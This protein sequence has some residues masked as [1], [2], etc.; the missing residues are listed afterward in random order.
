MFKSITSPV[1]VTHLQQNPPLTQ[2]NGSAVTD[3]LSSGRSVTARRTKPVDLFASQTEFG[4][5]HLTRTSGYMTLFSSNGA[6]RYRGPASY[7]SSCFG[8]D[9]S[10]APDLTF[11]ALD[12]RIRSKIKESNVNLAQSLAEYKQ[13]ASLFSDVVGT[14]Y[15]AYRGLRRGTTARDLSRMLKR[16]YDAQTKDLANRWLQYQ[17]GVKPLLSDI[18]GSCEALRK[19]LVT[20]TNKT[21][22]ARS[23][24]HYRGVQQKI[25]PISGAPYMVVTQKIVSKRVKA[26]YTISS[27]SLQALTSVGIT[28]PALLAWEL[29]PYSFVVDWLFPVGTWLASLDALNGTSNLVVNRGRMIDKVTTSTLGPVM[30]RD[31]SKLRLAGTSGLAL[32][33][34]GYKPSTSLTAVLNGLALLRQM[35]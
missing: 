16:P 31:V 18:H 7:F 1:F 12:A 8:I 25:E 26:R 32:P 27:A 19:A 20:G 34:L 21:V 15:S 30:E 11:Q 10:P 2:Q 22:S 13:T 28:N 6:Q 4:W 5:T 29:I 24:E 17:Y 33:K 23:T 14:V 9:A 35:R 3:F